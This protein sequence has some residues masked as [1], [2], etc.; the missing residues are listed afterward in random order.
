MTRYTM[1][2]DIK[3]TFNIEVLRGCDQID[4]TWHIT[5]YLLEIV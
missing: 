2:N 4:N 5:S 3:N 1:H